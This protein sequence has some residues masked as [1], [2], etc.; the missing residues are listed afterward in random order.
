MTTHKHAETEAKARGFDATIQGG[1]EWLQENS[2]EVV[3][4]IVAFLV[5]GAALAG[6]Y[7]WRESSELASQA[8]LARVERE[9][10]EALATDNQLALVVEPPNPE[11]LQEA[12]EQA[13]AAFEVMI[14]E[15]EGTPAA[16][17]AQI[18]AAEMLIDLERLDEAYASLEAGL[19]AFAEDDP[20]RGIVLRLQAYV[21]EEQERFA[22]AG[23]TF[24]EAARVK[25]YP[26]AASLWIA[27]AENFA[28]AGANERAIEAYQ[29]ALGADPEFAEQAGVLGRLGG[30]E[31]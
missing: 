28:R 12:R 16:R 24:A 31:R 5:I 8:A 20:L 18:R 13:V 11:Q 1:F 17:M 7:E 25:A 30:L 4:G 10:V 29:D 3:I 27:A 6:F 22:E 14:T 26:A 23:E 2:R 15:H 19:P 9:F 21:L